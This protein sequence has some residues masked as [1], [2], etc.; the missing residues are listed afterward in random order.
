MEMCGISK[1]VRMILG[2]LNDERKNDLVS[3]YDRSLER[4]FIKFDDLDKALM[5][6]PNIILDESER[7]SL[8]HYSGY[9][10]FSLNRAI[11]GKWNYEDNGH[12][13]LM[14][15]KKRQ[16]KDLMKVID[17]HQNSVGN[18]CVYR[19]VPL[20]Y[21]R[22]YGIYSIDDL[23]NLEGKF[24]LDEGFV[25]TSLVEKECFYRKNPKNGVNYNVMIEYLVPEEF[26]DGICT[27]YDSHFVNEGE[28]LINAWNLAEVVKVDKDGDDRAII[29]ALLIPK[30]VYDDF[31]VR[32]EEKVR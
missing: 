15:E 25:S 1:N 4:K 3:F 21:F 24:L 17:N 8:S 28:Y 12:I 11:R 30:K 14:E 31:Y 23:D 6:I 27:V 22:D 26:T 20:K 9:S 32:D 13:S 19:G 2:F 29:Q 5:F 7:L 16:A 10:Y 18:I